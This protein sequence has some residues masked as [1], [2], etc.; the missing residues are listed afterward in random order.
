MKQMHTTEQNIQMRIGV[1][2]LI[3]I[4]YFIGMF[5][6]SYHLRNNMNE[7]KE[8]ITKSHQLLSY[9]NS[10]IFSVQQGE[11]AINEYLISQQI[12]HLHRYDSISD[13]LLKQTARL[14][15]ITPDT[16][17]SELLK[18]IYVLLQE[19][20]TTARQLTRL[21]DLR[22][23]LTELDKKINVYKDKEAKQDSL[24]VT[25]NVDTTIK[26]DRRKGFW[27]RLKGLFNP[28]YA[29]DTTINI[30][31]ARTDTVFKTAA[32]SALYTDLKETS[33][34]ISNTYVSNIRGIEK[35]V[36]TL[37]LSEQKI[38]LQISELLTKLHQETIHTALSGIEKSSRL[39]RKVFDFS[40]ISGLV[41]LI[42]ILTIILLIF[43]DLKKGQK[44]RT[45]LIR[46][47]QRTE[48]L[49]KSRHQLLLSV[50]HDVKTPLS[51]IMGYMDIWESEEES[52]TKKQQIQSARNSGKY[53]LSML[54][55]LLEFSR[56]EQ[57]S[58]KLHFSQFNLIK[59]SY[60]IVDMFAPLAKEKKLAIL[61]NNQIRNP[62]YVESDFT[63]LKQ[64]LTNVL[65]NAVKYTKKG[66]VTLSL[67]QTEDGYTCFEVAD[68]GIGIRSEDIPEIFK[69]FS[70]MKNS[71][72]AEG[73]GF[74]MYV[75]KGFVDSLN[76]KI[77]ITSKKDQGTRVTLYLPLKEIRSPEKIEK[78]SEINKIP[79][80]LEKNILLFEDHAPL[81]FMLKDMLHHLGHRVTVCQHPED[82]TACLKNTS[83]F[84][85][86]LTD[87]DMGNITG[88]EI[89]RKIREKSA[90]IPV[91]IMTAY[92]DYTQEAATTDGF[93][94]FLRKPICSE[95]LARIVSVKTPETPSE[96][97]IEKEFP[98]LFSMF[99]NDTKTIKNILSTFV[100]KSRDDI[101]ELERCVRENDF[102]AAQHVCHKIHPFLAQLNAENICNN[103]KK[104]DQ[105]RGK[106]VT[107][108]PNWKDDMRKTAG[109]IRLLTERI[110]NEYLN[111]KG[112][113]GVIT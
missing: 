110:K 94:G 17:K 44:A 14:K 89:L 27:E 74:G 91:W 39:N 112:E 48:T 8:E 87:M 62:F 58:G 63:I 75:T 31:N 34:K 80:Y 10:F 3:L 98:V 113:S 60:E 32:D 96:K 11:N 86:V 2:I 42:L 102:S 59:L 67:R 65:S 54:T 52:K 20:N 57:K 43:D 83:S 28:K 35:Q 12:S 22:D 97:F 38:S 33:Q 95:E 101:R 46:E 100:E 9:T 90:E 53:I 108:Y 47:K 55:N 88:I 21:F 78:D 66:S 84:D 45:E 49:M 29:A 4:L 64:I 109:D 40:I 24:V 73:S 23:P 15:I 37:V 92:D 72:N 7:R 13:N 25:K 61:F 103:L 79:N 71:V 111:Q 19:K 5:I 50:S 81:A 70:R 106:D 69:P 105:L 93:D 104:M 68:T 76:G 6:Y 99:D 77:S 85:L 82:V 36:Q 26:V 107:L 1:I 56:L 30:T 51:S 18:K 16:A 41:S